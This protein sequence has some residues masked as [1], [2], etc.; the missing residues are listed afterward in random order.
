[1]DGRISTQVGTEK[2]G[3]NDVLCFTDGH[4][5]DSRL[6]HHQRRNQGVEKLELDPKGT[7][8]IP[9]LHDYLPCQGS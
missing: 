7:R 9:K 2:P 8:L 3:Q 4:R 1:M 6:A 5:S